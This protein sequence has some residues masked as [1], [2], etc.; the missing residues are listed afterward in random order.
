MSQYG[1]QLKVAG[2]VSELMLIIVGLAQG[3]PLSGFCFTAFLD[4]LSTLFEEEGVGAA[5]L[6][7]ALV[8]IFFMDDLTIFATSA[9]MVRKVLALL[10]AYKQTW[11][12]AYAP[13][14]K[15]G[16]LVSG[17][18]TK[19]KYWKLGD[20]MIPTVENTKILGVFF[21]GEGSWKK[22]VM[23]KVGGALGRFNSLR[24]CGLVGGSLSLE[25]SGVYVSSI[26]WATLHYGRASTF[27]Y[28]E[29]HRLD[30]RQMVT[31]YDKIARVTLGVSPRAATAG[32][33]A[34]LGCLPEGCGPPSAAPL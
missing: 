22:H 17:G 4:D 11:R 6:G 12:L 27:L 26:V 30:R 29:E 7:L 23:A 20:M 28:L 34:K 1:T 24:N 10:E 8:G 19:V 21:S 15:S 5:V 25:M 13:P 16:V 2:A 33:L 31:A 18:V 3:S 14:P 32:G 9:A